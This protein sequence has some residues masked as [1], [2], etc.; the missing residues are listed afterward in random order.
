MKHTI[1]VVD[2]A[3]GQVTQIAEGSDFAGAVAWS[4]DGTRLAYYL[5]L[6]T[7]APSQVYVLDMATGATTQVT[8]LDA[9]DR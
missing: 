4:P 9:N 1:S 8:G 7:G 2:V 6:V 5:Q 3:S